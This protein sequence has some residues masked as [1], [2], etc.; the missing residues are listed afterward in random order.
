MFVHDVCCWE[1]GIVAKSRMLS[2]RQTGSRW[3]SAP[4]VR[5]SNA[6]TKR[7]PQHPLSNRYCSWQRC[8]ICISWIQSLPV[9][10]QKLP[11]WHWREGTT[12][13]H[14]QPQ[15]GCTR[16]PLCFCSL[17]TGWALLCSA[18]RCV[19]SWRRPCT[20][21]VVDLSLLSFKPSCCRL[22]S[23]SSYPAFL[24]TAGC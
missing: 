22:N 9:Q 17:N 2:Q 5:F 13:S 14:T 10:F 23:V 12:P 3:C 18:P 4:P 24:M 16:P 7:S 8:C 20:C 19:Q 11:S 6:S 15:H 21:F 1:C